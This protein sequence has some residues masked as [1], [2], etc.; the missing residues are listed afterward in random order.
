MP[1]DDI[2]ELLD[3]VRYMK[4]ENELH[5]HTTI[6]GRKQKREAPIYANVFEMVEKRIL[7]ETKLNSL[8]EK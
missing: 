2:E 8:K 3:W 7:R 1:R 4:R 5:I 6:W